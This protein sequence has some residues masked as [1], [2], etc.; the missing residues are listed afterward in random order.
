MGMMGRTSDIDVVPYECVRSA[1]RQQWN[2]TAIR[3]IAPTCTVASSHRRTVAPSHRRTVAPS[4]PSHRR[5]VAPSHRRTVAPSHRRTVAPSHRRTVAPSQRRT[6]APSHR[7]IVASSHR[8]TVAP[9][10]RRGRGKRVPPLGHELR[11]GIGDG[12]KCGGGRDC[13]RLLLRDRLCSGRRSAALRSSLSWRPY[14]FAEGAIGNT[15]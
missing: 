13:C 1:P 14:I 9:S 5:T 8:R 3:R 4:H 2:I 15:Q 10:H 7:R 12:S 11:A 6:V